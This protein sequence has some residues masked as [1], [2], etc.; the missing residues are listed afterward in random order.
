VAQEAKA[1]GM[2]ATDFIVETL[3]RRLAVSCSVCGRTD[4]PVGGAGLSEAFD[5]FTAK[6]RADRNMSP[7]AIAAIAPTGTVAYRG[8]LVMN[9]PSQGMLLLAVDFNQGRAQMTVE[10]P[11][12][13]G[14]I[15]G[16]QEDPQRD[17]HHQRLLALGYRNGNDAAI[18]SSLRN[19]RLQ[20]VTA[21][22]VSDAVCAV[23][24]MKDEA[25]RQYVGLYNAPL[26]A[27]LLM[28]RHIIRVEN[29]GYMS[30]FKDPDVALRVARERG[31][32]IDMDLGG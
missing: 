28:D 9:E 3:E 2:T 19:R 4:R 23:P 5:D 30:N 13:R 27:S 25:L 20:T 16:W 15:T 17:G 32:D 14:I 18:R 21:R 10:V 12:P 11:V 8:R 1:H 29:G 22:V 24:G 6:L 7:I 26:G 31:I